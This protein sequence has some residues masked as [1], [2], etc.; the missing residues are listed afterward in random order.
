METKKVLLSDLKGKK[1]GKAIN[2]IVIQNRL[3]KLD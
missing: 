1:Q 3:H 2:K